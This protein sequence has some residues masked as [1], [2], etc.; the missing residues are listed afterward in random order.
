MDPPGASRVGPDMRVLIVLLLLASP[1]A[2]EVLDRPTLMQVADDGT[3]TELPLVRGAAHVD[4]R[5]PIG[6]V[7]VTQTFANPNETPIEA[8]YVF[9]LPEDAAIGGL[10]MRLGKRTIV[11]E[12][13]EREEARAV[14]EAAREAGQTAALLDQERPNVFTQH[15]ANIL[16]GE[17]ITVELTYDLLLEPVAG[18]FELAIPTVVGPRYEGI[19]PKV[20]EP[21]TSSG[22][23]LAVDL[24][25]DAGLPITE[26]TSPTHDITT[27]EV[28]ADR[29]QVTLTDGDAVSDKDFVLRWSVVVKEPTLAVLADHAGDDGYLSLIV[30]PPP[31]TATQH[32]PRELVFV[33]DTS[34]SMDGEPLS[35]ARRAMRWALD[36]LEPTDAFRILNFSTDV[37]GFDDGAVVEA[38]RD[39]VRRARSWINALTSGGGTEMIRGIEAALPGAPEGDRTRYVCFMTDGYIGN[40]DEILAAVEERLDDHTHLFSFGVG[41]SVNRYLL[42]GL[43]QQGKGVARYLLL[44]EEPGPQI[45]AFFAQ[46]ASPMLEDLTIDWDG[47]DV[48]DPTPAS[49]GSLFAGQP[50]VVSARYGKGGEGTIVVKAKRAGKKV[51]LEIP[52]RLPD[53]AGDGAVLARLWARRRIADLDDPTE[54]TKIALAHALMSAYTSFVAVDRRVRAGGKYETVEVPVEMPMGVSMQGDAYGVSFSGSTGG[55]SIYI[56]DSVPVIDPTSTQL[57]VTIDGR[58]LTG[59][60][61]SGG[62][63]AID[64]L[65]L[66]WGTPARTWRGHV[67]LLLGVERDHGE[68]SGVTMGFERR[69]ISRFAAGMSA[70]F[71]DRDEAPSIAAILATLT[72]WSLLDFL[73]VRVGVGGSFTREGAGPAAGARLAI[74]IPV[75]SRLHPELELRIDVARPGDEDLVGGAMGVGVRF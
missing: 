18:V 34:G 10:T 72:S 71:W 19:T 7:V 2:A 65:E 39:N 52:V 37:A 36:R 41:S 28:D 43:A 38:T 63:P 58:M 51:K 55:E 8:I 66:G 50:I 42:D 67:D 4:V 59:A 1:A 44:D 5:G 30:Q 35:L 22:N 27:T 29:V 75:G 3:R 23:T 62:G 60:I 20:V 73:D 16:P 31:A 48:D 6:Q 9:P 25:I 15:V 49:L 14:Y 46:V 57:G 33:V 24:D 47:L 12:I 13:R 69:L 68:L 26:V 45:E 74:P 40:E 11:A 21:G 64:G 32:E 61:S 53:K 70:T 56:V 17:Q 54:I